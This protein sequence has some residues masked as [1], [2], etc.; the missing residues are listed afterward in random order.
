MGNMKPYPHAACAHEGLSSAGEPIRM[1]SSVVTRPACAHMGHARQSV[2]AEASSAS[3]F[4]HTATTTIAPVP[5]FGA[6]APAMPVYVAAA[7]RESGIEFGPG[8]A[9]RA[10]AG[11]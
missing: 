9:L 1:R 4:A 5:E 8:L 7:G 2:G 3:G 10:G 6:A 11:R